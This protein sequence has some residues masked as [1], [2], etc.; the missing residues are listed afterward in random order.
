MQIGKAHHPTHL[1]PSDSNTNMKV[2]FCQHPQ[3][4]IIPRAL[5]AQDAFSRL[6]WSHSLQVPAFI[7]SLFLIAVVWP[8]CG[9]QL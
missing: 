9:A 1:A 6:L 4:L 7:L 5:G 3:V 2:Q 8:W